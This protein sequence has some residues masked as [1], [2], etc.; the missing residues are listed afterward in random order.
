MNK[1]IALGALLLP[2]TLAGCEHRTVVVYNAPPPP[3][4][5]TEAGRQ[6][7][8]D[9]VAAA[10]RD[11]ARGNPLVVDRHPRFRNPPVPLP[12]FEDF[13]HGFRDGYEQVIHHGAQ[14]PGY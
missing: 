13:R 6:G 8:N 7:Y 2:I 9:G 1:W 10:Q 4:A 14:P 5:Y 11:I 12:L 3:A